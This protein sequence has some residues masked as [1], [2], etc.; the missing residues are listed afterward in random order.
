MQSEH[1]KPFIDQTIEILDEFSIKVSNKSPYLAK[2]EDIC[3]CDI[4][5]TIGI[6]GDVSAVVSISFKNKLA[7]RIGCAFYQED[8]IT[9]D[10]MV[11]AIMELINCIA[12]RA[13]EKLQ[14]YKLHLTPPSL[15]VGIKHKV[16]LSAKGSIVVIPF[17]TADSSDVFNL[18]VAISQ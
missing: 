3:N 6:S 5:A 7:R 16:Y 12:G 13:K 9:D 14:K 15:T 2:R 1:I 10:Q 4:S 11:D 18:S 17:I 8:T